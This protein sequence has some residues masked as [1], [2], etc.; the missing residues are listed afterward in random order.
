MRRVLS[1]PV[2]VSISKD[3]H[4]ALFAG[5]VNGRG[6]PT[7][8]RHVV[9]AAS[10]TD[11]D[12]T[13]T[14]ADIGGGSS[15]DLARAEQLSVSATLLVLLI[16]FGTLVAAAVPVLLA[17]TAVAAAFGL[18]GP[19]SHLFALDDSVKTVVLLIGMAV[20]VDY[21]L[22]YTVRAREERR[23]GLPSHAAL[24]RTARYVRSLG[25]D[26]GHECDD[27]DGGPVCDRV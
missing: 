22:F 24:D 20:G 8:L 16:V 13:A 10:G 1:S 2:E 14:V 9:S 11:R 3:R 4:A 6:S 19:I 12:I 21:T 25:G 27:R 18:L 7:E 15:Q 26:R 23:R 5:Q 17:V